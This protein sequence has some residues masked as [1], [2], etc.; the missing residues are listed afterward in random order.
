MKNKIGL[1]GGTFNP[2]HLGHIELGLQILDAF[3]LEK[4]LYILSAY[5]PH[6]K[7][8]KIVPAEIRWKMLN[9]A[10]EPF[11]QLVPCDIEMKRSTWSWTVDTVKELRKK[12]PGTEFYFISGSEGFLKIRTWKNYKNLL[13][14]LTFIVVLRKP[15]HKQAVEILL[16]EENISLSPH[17]P[18]V[19]IFY[20]ES[21]KLFISS[22]LIREKMKLSQQIDDFV[23]KEVKKIMEEYKL[24]ES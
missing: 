7:N 17:Y 6:K 20:Y 3:Q 9:K 19:H 23:V 16:K 15:G 4:I 22:T 21:D 5:P 8:K 1:L 13:N 12:F 11:P 14:S 24:Y 18:S 2:I 10:L